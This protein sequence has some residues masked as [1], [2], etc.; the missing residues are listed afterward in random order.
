M[1]AFVL[2]LDQ[3]NMFLIGQ[4]LEHPLSFIEKFATV[5]Y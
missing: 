3:L 4:P 5:M 1:V 2:A